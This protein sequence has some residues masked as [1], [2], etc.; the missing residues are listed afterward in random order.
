[1]KCTYVCIRKGTRISPR[2]FKEMETKY[3]EL[4][5]YKTIGKARDGGCMLQITA[6]LTY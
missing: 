5:A 4:K 6:E 3:R 1:M 2:F